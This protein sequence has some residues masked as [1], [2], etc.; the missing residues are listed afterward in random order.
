MRE[1][2]KATKKIEKILINAEDTGESFDVTLGNLSEVKVHGVVFP[3]LMRIEIMDAFV[4]DRHNRT[5][6]TDD[7]VQGAYDLA[8][9]KWNNVN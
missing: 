7:D 2:T 5:V 6:K 8:A 1:L 3:R 4:D 9:M